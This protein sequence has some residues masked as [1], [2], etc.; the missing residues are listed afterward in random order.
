MELLRRQM[1]SNPKAFSETVRR[2]ALLALAGCEDDLDPRTRSMMEFMIRSGALSKNNRTTGYLGFGI[3]RAVDQIALGRWEAA[4]ATLLS[5]LVA[6]EQSSRDQGRW[7]LA[8]LLTHLPEPPWHQMVQHAGG[9]QLRPFGHLA[10]PS[11]T[12]AAM[13][14]TKDAVALAEVRKKFG[15]DKRPLTGSGGSEDAPVPKRQGGGRGG[16]G[17]QAPKQ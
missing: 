6:I 16:G 7:Q 11:W 10:D 14:F 17:A 2:N 8:W 13:A 3:A 9:E 12:A 4:E 15:E 1:Q 5:L